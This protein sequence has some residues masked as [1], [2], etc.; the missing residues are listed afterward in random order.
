M[1][2][3]KTN[4]GSP[5]WK[6]KSIFAPGFAQKRLDIMGTTTFRSYIK[7]LCRVLTAQGNFGLRR[8]NQPRRSIF[9]LMHVLVSRLNCCMIGQRSRKLVAAWRMLLGL[10]RELVMQRKGQNRAEKQPS[11]TYPSRKDP[12]EMAFSPK[13]HRCCHS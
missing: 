4:S 6:E 1:A 10:Y 7:E 2:W 3:L 13:D 11:L 9:C 12:L 8:L 5:Q